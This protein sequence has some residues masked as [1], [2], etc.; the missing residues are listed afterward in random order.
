MPFTLH[1][2]RKTSASKMLT[3][4]TVLGYFSMAILYHWP[5]SGW[6]RKYRGLAQRIRAE[7]PCQDRQA[8]GAQFCKD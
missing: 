6:R 5:F 8:A 1:Y 4:I 3:S 2:D 7:G